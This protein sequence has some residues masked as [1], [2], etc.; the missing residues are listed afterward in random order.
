MKDDYREKQK[1]CI[2]CYYGEICP[3]DVVCE[4]Y[5]PLDDFEIAEQEYDENLYIRYLDYLEIIDE[6]GGE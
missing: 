3:A 2:N 1:S 4:F 5:D 6:F